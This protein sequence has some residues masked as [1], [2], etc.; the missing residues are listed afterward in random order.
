MDVNAS[1]ACEDWWDLTE[2]NNLYEMMY[3]SLIRDIQFRQQLL[4]SQK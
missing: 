3:D 4:Q 2:T 1:L